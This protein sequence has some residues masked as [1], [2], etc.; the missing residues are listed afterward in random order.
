MLRLSIWL[1]VAALSTLPLAAMAADGPIPA[2]EAPSRFDLPP[3][4]QV[5]LFAGEPD[6]V[7]P[8]AMTID[9]RGRLWVVECLSYPN[10]QKTG[11]D[12]ILIFTDKDN[13]GKF[14]E[15]KVFF[16]EGANYSGIEVG[17]GG[18]WVC[19]TPFLLF[20]PD[21]NHD[22]QPDG[23]PEA[24]LDGWDLKAKHNVFAALKWGPDG[25]LYGCNGIMSNSRVGAPGT[26]D[27]LRTPIN[28][29]VWR[30]HPISQRFEA[31]AHGTTNPWGLDFDQYGQIFI[32]NCVIHHL[33]HMV[34]GACTERMYG[35]HFNPHLYTL[36]KSCADYIHWAGGAWQSSRGGVGEHSK[37]GGGHAHAGAMVYLGDN[38]PAEYRGSIFTCNIHGNRLNSDRLVRKGSGYAA[39]RGPDLMF[40]NDPWFRSLAVM[41]GPDGGVYVADWC[42]TGECHDYDDVH[43][44]SGRIYKVTHGK[45]AAPKLD[46]TSAK[47]AALVALHT[48]PNEWFVTHARRILQEKAAAGEDLSAIKPA[49]VEIY[50]KH[51]EVTT[52]LKAFWT[53]HCI[54]ALTEGDLLAATQNES[55]YLRAWA[56]RFLCETEPSAA[57]L[58]KLADMAEQEPSPWV[59]LELASSLQRLPIPARLGIARGLVRHGDV[60]DDQNLP[61]MIWYGIEPLVAADT[62]AAVELLKVTQIPFVRESIARRIASLAK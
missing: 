54:R 62:V 6:V 49:L 13:D 56:I 29:G 12:R 17:F 38:W 37:F 31:V 40:A 19:A 25:W 47:P 60:S 7:Q 61:Y 22:D 33:W 48:H 5:S 57:V 50:E 14:D 2:A 23:P 27:H 59:Q 24:I 28:C 9:D 43:R 51:A 42:D 39:E 44:T 46:L 20:I 52:R 16:S 30:F 11:R 41:Y 3:G 45:P 15:R 10:W 55:E 18:V 34:P 26:A 53:L 36:M 32:T 8:I 58:S 35:Q 21:R 4:F 1:C